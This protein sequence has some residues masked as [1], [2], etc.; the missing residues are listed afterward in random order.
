M[1][2]F[3]MAIFLGGGLSLAGC[4]AGDHGD[5]P[6]LTTRA[7]TTSPR[8]PSGIVYMKEPRDIQ[9]SAPGTA[10]C[11]R[12]TAADAAIALAATNAARQSRGL[13][14]LRTN[15]R[16]QRAAEAHA[17][18]MARNGMMT[19]RGR[20]GTGPSA[21]VKKAGY[22]PRITAENIAAGHFDVGRVQKEWTR[23][24]GHR[25]NIMI[26]G[27]QDYGIGRAV[28]EDGKA[29]YWVAIYGSPK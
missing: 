6:D 23:S 28:A 13:A 19:H 3:A 5:T 16:L 24:P 26:G 21:R 8:L 17:C 12:T 25:A 15:P 4:G 22:A 1:R 2:H 27:L 18:E 14:P 7:S 10:Q 9:V 11:H 20:G 29:S